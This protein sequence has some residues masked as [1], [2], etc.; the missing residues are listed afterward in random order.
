M[1]N[2]EFGRLGNCFIYLYL[3]NMYSLFIFIIYVQYAY[4]YIQVY[5]Y[6][7]V[8]MLSCIY[9]IYILYIYVYIFID[10]VWG[11]V[12]RVELGFCFLLFLR[13]WRKQVLFFLFLDIVGDKGRQ[14]YIYEGCFILR[15]QGGV[16]FGRSG[17]V[18]IRKTSGD[19]FF[20]LWFSL[21]FRV[22]GMSLQFIVWVGGV[23]GEGGT[24]LGK[25]KSRFFRDYEKYV[26][27]KNF[28]LL[29]FF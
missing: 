27:G 8:Y 11:R 9:I 10:L 19:V 26:N 16:C 15:T 4:T 22:G 28:N 7:F 24:E 3:L 6:I 5:I 12:F 25:G 18:I 29:F 21:L 1:G 14:R 20:F 23:V 13:V 2:I 17:W